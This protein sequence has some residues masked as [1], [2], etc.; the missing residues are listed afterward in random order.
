MTETPVSAS[1]AAH[2]RALKATA[3]VSVQYVRGG[4]P[5]SLVAVPGRTNFAPPGAMAAVFAVCKPQ[6]WIVAAADLPAAPASGDT[7]VWGSD[8]Y[9][10]VPVGRRRWYSPMDA[11]GHAY[12]LHTINVD[13]AH[14]VTLQKFTQ[15]STDNRGQP[16]GTWGTDVADLAAAVIPRGERNAEL[17]HA[18][19]ESTTHQVLMRYRAD[20]TS[21][22]RLSYDGRTL[23]IGHV[24]IVDEMGLFLSLSCT[25]EI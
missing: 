4:T 5:T 1:A 13:L 2:V 22:K 15:T 12:R 24:E 14:S 25:E 6:D 11:G 8:T 7:I 19:H 3:G 20:V 18:F 17:A 9:D 10:L 21:A 16:V 23:A